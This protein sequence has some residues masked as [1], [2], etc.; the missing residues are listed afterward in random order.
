MKFPVNNLKINPIFDEIVTKKMANLIIKLLATKTKYEIST[1]LPN[2]EKYEAKDILLNSKYYKK[3]E[4][5]DKYH[6]HFNNYFTGKK[7][8][9]CRIVIIYL[10]N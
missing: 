10:S 4:E 5:F 8:C 7:I 3:K 9:P 2:W 1:I 6:L